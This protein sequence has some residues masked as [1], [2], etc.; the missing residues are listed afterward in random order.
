M[1]TWSVNIRERASRPIASKHKALRICRVQFFN[2]DAYLVDSIHRGMLTTGELA[3]AEKYSGSKR[4][5]G[6]S[7]VKAI[8]YAGIIPGTKV[9]TGPKEWQVIQERK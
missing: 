9:D 2:A 1:A 3:L 4:I 8:T 6:T 5:D 7:F